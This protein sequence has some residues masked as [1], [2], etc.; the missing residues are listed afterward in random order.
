[1]QIVSWHW[2]RTLA[3][4]T[5]GRKLGSSHTFFHKKQRHI[6]LRELVLYFY[7][8]SEIK[9]ID[10]KFNAEVCG[11]SFFAFAKFSIFVRYFNGIRSKI[12]LKENNVFGT[13][14]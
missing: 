1:M 11:H 7:S 9:N 10:L 8:S 12:D 13:T 3:S 2:R 5:D 6:Y 4:S 14:I